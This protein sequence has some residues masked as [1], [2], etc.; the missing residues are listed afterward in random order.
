MKRRALVAGVGNIFLGDDGFGVEVAVRLAR[1]TMPEGVEVADFGIR[2]VH[3]AYELL[4]GCELLVLVDA[5][6]RGLD[7]GTVSVIE[8]D[9]TVPEGTPEGGPGIASAPM[10]AHGLE[11][12][13]VLA[14]LA[15]LGGSVGRVLVVACEPAET[16]EGIGLSPKVE[17]AVDDAV[18]AVERILDT[19]LRAR[20]GPAA[21]T[22]DK[23]ESRC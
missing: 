19:Q 21:S 1:R 7:P 13:A 14:L 15:S 6:A 18:A 12:H 11:P 9:P 20:P 10:D 22:K 3:L 4:D 17:A 8:V 23:E 2:G 16:A 5:A